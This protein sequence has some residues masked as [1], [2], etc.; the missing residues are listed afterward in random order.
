MKTY[1]VTTDDIGNNVRDL[2]QLVFDVTQRCNLRCKYCI[3]SGMY[4]GF[5]NHRGIS[6][7]DR[8]ALGL[9]EYLGN[10]WKEDAYGCSQIVNIGFFGGE[11]LLN[12]P[13]IEKIVRYTKQKE[14][15]YGRKFSYS[16]T[17]NA[18]LLRK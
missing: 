12:F 18:L 3:Y 8:V 1:H 13:L 9:L 15:E 7:P 10:I 6:M 4:E 5:D 11:P 17:T 16:M 2:S 14:S